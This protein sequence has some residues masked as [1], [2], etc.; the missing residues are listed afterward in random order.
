MR[1]RSRW[2]GGWRRNQW[3]ASSNHGWYRGALT[4]PL[5]ASPFLVPAMTRNMNRPLSLPSTG[6][7]FTT[8]EAPS[9]FRSWERC[10]INRFVVWTYYCQ[11]QKSTVWRARGEVCMGVG[12]HFDF[13]FDEKFVLQCTRR[14]NNGGTPRGK[15]RC[16]CFLYLLHDS[17]SNTSRQRSESQRTRFSPAGK[18]HLATWRGLV[19]LHFARL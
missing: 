18:S 13:D 8:F 14:A 6:S 19:L 4:I 3:P 9:S 2:G 7:I 12:F 16:V 1:G 15:H 10:K 17:A 5:K 11:R